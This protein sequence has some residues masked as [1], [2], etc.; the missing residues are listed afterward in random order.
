MQ[1]IKLNT[2]EKRVAK[3]FKYHAA[4]Y[5]ARTVLQSGTFGDAVKKGVFSVSAWDHNITVTL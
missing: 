5:T 2:P 1:I 3:T 4:G